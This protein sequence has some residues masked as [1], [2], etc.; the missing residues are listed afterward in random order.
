MQGTRDPKSPVL[1]GD[2]EDWVVSINPRYVRGLEMQRVWQT[3]PVRSDPPRQ[4]LECWELSWDYG[5]EHR[6]GAGNPEWDLTCT[7]ARVGRPS[8]PV[9][10]SGSFPPDL[11]L[12]SQEGRTGG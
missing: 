4:R 12:L 11:P 8:P 10:P 7:G 9:S 3:L 2:S 6:D 1:G 5:C